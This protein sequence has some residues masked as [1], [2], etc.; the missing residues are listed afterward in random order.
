[1]HDDRGR[2][3]GR[4]LIPSADRG[5]LIQTVLSRRPARSQGDELRKQREQN[6]Q[7]DEE[8]IY[9]VLADERKHPQP[10]QPA[11]R[12]KVQECPKGTWCHKQ[13]INLARKRNKMH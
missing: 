1:M 4:P 13:S 6:V 5:R 12:N 10:V 8:S 11:Y 9:Q 2:E 3:G 7:G